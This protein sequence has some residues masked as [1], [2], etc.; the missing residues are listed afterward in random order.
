M[1][2]CVWSR[3]PQ[4]WGGHDPRWV[5]A[6]QKSR[7]FKHGPRTSPRQMP[8]PFAIKRRDAHSLVFY[9]W[10]ISNLGPADCTASITGK[11]KNGKESGM[12]DCSWQNQGLSPGF[13]REVVRS[14]DVLSKIR[15]EHLKYTNPQNSPSRKIGMCACLSHRTCRGRLELKQRVAR[16]LQCVCVRACACVCVWGGA[17]SYVTYKWTLR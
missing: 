7:S 1:R 11:T 3:K 5:E 8:W 16:D 17:K 2:R 6:P 9:F 14:P 12:K 4:E 15:K 10:F 13:P